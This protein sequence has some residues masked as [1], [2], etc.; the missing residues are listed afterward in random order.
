MFFLPALQP[1]SGGNLTLQGTLFQH[2]AARIQG[3]GLRVSGANSLVVHI[4]HSSFYGN[5]AARQGGAVV[6]SAS[7]GLNITV[8]NTSFHDND[9]LESDGG[10]LYVEVC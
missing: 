5:A 9:A 1:S 2:N 10:G 3:A 4:I 6:V 8:H 7:E